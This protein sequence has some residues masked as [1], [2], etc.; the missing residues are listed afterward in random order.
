MRLLS[1]IAR[2]NRQGATTRTFLAVAA[3][4]TSACGSSNPPNVS[5]NVGG[6]SQID[7][8]VE[9][10]SDASASNIE[11]AGGASDGGPSS[12]GPDGAPSDAESGSDG[13]AASDAALETGSAVLPICREGFT[14][15]T[16]ARV[17]SIA[18][19]GFDRFGAISADEL[20]VAWTTAAGTIYVAD[21]TSNT[22]DFGPPEAIDP[23]SMQL[24]NGRVALMP[25][26]LELIATLADG[27]SFTAFDRVSTML[28]NWQPST[29]DEFKF[30]AATITESGGSFAEPV[31]S[32]DGQ[33]LFYLLTIGPALPV[34]YE[35]PWDSGSQTWQ[36][37][38]PIAGSEFVA[39]DGSATD[40]GAAMLVRRPTGA[41]SDRLTLFYFDEVLG[42]ELG[43][44]RSSL[45]EPFET[46]ADLA[47]LPEVAPSADCAYVYFHGTDDAGQG[48]F[49]GTGP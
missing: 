48:L 15:S 12:R 40:G 25:D 2:V 28:S 23:G 5:G 11:G 22:G 47:N 38:Q 19:T 32:A 3:S 31:V 30:I 37:G 49:T 10:S 7:S 33:S 36:L 20:T 29:S 35:S 41:S 13:G 26:G 46:F 17:P 42:H 45:G 8:S 34:L 4:I 9:A 16:T 14:W 43:A 1:R 6:F 21:R 39:Q 24:A 44:W 27:S 18:S